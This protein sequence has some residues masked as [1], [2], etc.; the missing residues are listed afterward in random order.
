[1]PIDAISGCDY[2]LLIHI[3]FDHAQNLDCARM[4]PV[5]NGDVIRMDDITI[6]IFTGRHSE[7]PRGYR[8]SGR[9]FRKSDGTRILIWAGMTSSDQKNRFR[10]IHP[11]IALMHVSP[12]QD[13]GEF[14]SLTAAMGAKII[15]PHHCDC[16]EKLFEAVPDAIMDMSEENRCCFVA[17]GRFLFPRYLEALGMAC[18]EQNPAAE[19]LM[20][21]HHKINIVIYRTSRCAFRCGPESAPA[22]HPRYGR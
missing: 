8:P 3:H 11:D 18:K 13:F 22:H 1:M 12:K 16:T 6:Q 4:F 15:I 17:D 10:G 5:R 21:E 20:M 2:L 19:L 7:S 9:G 14:A